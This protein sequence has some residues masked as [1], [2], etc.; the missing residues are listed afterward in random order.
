MFCR[1][2]ELKVM[3][4]GNCIICGKKVGSIE[5]LL[6]YR[7]GDHRVCLGCY[8]RIASSS[9]ITRKIPSPTSTVVK[10]LFGI[11]FIATTPS[12]SS[13]AT[14]LIA[15]VIGVALIA[16][17]LVPVYLIRTTCDSAVALAI[18]RSRPT[19]GA[20]VSCENTLR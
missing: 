8:N 18:G 17:A 2:G 4:S 13:A 16:W 20:P 12:Q 9:G 7:Q 3:S 15:I 10:L 19:M 1:K 14:V 6:A 5:R 11:L